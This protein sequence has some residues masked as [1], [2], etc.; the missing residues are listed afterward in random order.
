MSQPRIVFAEDDLNLAE[1]IR[2]FLERNELSVTT[3]ADGRDVIQTVL[4]E[5][6]DLLLQQIAAVHRHKGSSAHGFENQ[7]AVN[8]L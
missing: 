5:Q 1:L 2:T 4:R 7:T 6:P 8:R 3:V